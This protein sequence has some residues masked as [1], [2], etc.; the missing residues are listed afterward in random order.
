MGFAEIF[1]GVKKSFTEKF[2]T[3]KEKQKQNL[4]ARQ[5]METKREDEDFALDPRSPYSTEPT[6]VEPAELRPSEPDEPR[7]GFLG[8]VLD[9][10]EDVKEKWDQRKITYTRLPGTGGHL[11]DVKGRSIMA[12]VANA[13]NEDEAAPEEEQ[14]P[15]PAEAPKAPKPTFH[16]RDIIWREKENVPAVATPEG[17]ERDI[18]TFSIDEFPEIEP[19]QKLTIT[20]KGSGAVHEITDPRQLEVANT[21]KRVSDAVAP[22]YTSYLLR[23]A[24]FEGL[25]Y[26]DTRNYMFNDTFINSEG[27]EVHYSSRNPEDAEKYG[28]LWS[29]DRGVFQINDAAFPA[30]PDEVADDPVRATLFVLSAIEA[31]KQDKWYADQRTKNAKL[32]YE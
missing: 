9:V 17:E 29:T 6:T 16:A 26:P 27:K 25:L 15:A 8:K 3:L 1:G 32:K 24:N 31:E 2:Q 12:S 18:T 23:L 7:E 19:I 4:A 5:S 22:E 20:E 10:A 13:F 14:Q 11:Q 30:I 21:I 28:G